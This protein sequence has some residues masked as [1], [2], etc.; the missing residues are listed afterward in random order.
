MAKAC[1]SPSNSRIFPRKEAHS[2]SDPAPRNGSEA[3]PGVKVSTNCR[4]AVKLTANQLIAYHIHVKP[5][6]GNCT[7]TGAHLDPYNRGEDPPCDASQPDTCQVG[8]LSGKHGKITSDPF[9][10]QY[11]DPYLTLV[12]GEPA[13][14]GN[15]SFVVHFANKTRITCA[16]FESQSGK[17]SPTNTTTPPVATGTGAPTTVPTTTG[18]VPVP[19]AGSAL[20]APIRLV[21]V[22]VALMM[23]A[24]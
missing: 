9:E 23:F 17:P 1:N 16:N 6:E 19:A 13:F 12:E 11:T 18:V 24:F 22:G 15:R 5:S 3:G 20:E 2:V 10:V 8:D 21:A 4:S 14:F 7:A